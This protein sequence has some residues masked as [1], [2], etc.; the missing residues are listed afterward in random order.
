MTGIPENDVVQVLGIY[1]FLE[2]LLPQLILSIILLI[3]FMMAHYR[4]KI[5]VLK[6]DYEAKLTEAK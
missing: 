5:A 1:P 4:Q 2:T 3:T 6:K